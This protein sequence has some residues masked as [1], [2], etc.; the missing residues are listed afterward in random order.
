MQKEIVPVE[1]E[2]RKSLSIGKGN[3]PE[4]P[5][6]E[7]KSS[8]KPIESKATLSPATLSPKVNNCSYMYNESLLLAE[9]IVFA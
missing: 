9:Y 8:L 3:L 4:K 7:S 2:K 5:E 6:P 1:P